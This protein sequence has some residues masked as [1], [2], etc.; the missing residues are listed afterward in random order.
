LIDPREHELPL[1]NGDLE[2][3]QGLPDAALLL[4][5]AFEGADGLLFCS[6]EYNSSITPLLKNL[7][8]W[9]SRPAGDDEPPLSAYRGKVAGLVSASPGALGG[10]RGLVHLR[11]I[12]GNIG[13]HVI[14]AQYALG[15]A[16]GKFDDGGELVDEEALGK[17]TAVL[18]ELIGTASRLSP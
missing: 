8:D 14:P 6:P 9:V 16:Y 7:I 18:E 1:Y 12:L 13:V 2:E 10:L 15:G 4:K 17:L 5:K 11:S 3:E